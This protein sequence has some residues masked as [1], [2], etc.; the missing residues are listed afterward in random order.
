MQFETNEYLDEVCEPKRPHR[1]TA[2]KLAA[3]DIN[4]ALAPHEKKG[5]LDLLSN[6]ADCFAW[7]TDNIGHF[8]YG[9]DMEID[10]GDSPPIHLPPYA[11]GSKEKEIIDKQIEAWLKAGIIRPS[12]SNYSAPIF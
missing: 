8:E 7:D 9:P 5:I 12:T 11:L 6:Y 1:M 4:K 10:T 3:V 2:S